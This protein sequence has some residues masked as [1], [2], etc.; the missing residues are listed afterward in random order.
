MVARTLTATAKAGVRAVCSA[1]L[2]FLLLSFGNLT[3]CT[4]C[5]GTDGPAGFE[6]DLVAGT[7]LAMRRFFEL[8]VLLMVGQESARR[9]MGTWLGMMSLLASAG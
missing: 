7:D 9:I 5:L 8:G 6:Q 1:D 4:P 3:N 2:H